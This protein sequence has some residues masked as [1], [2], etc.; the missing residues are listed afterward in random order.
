[1]FVFSAFAPTLILCML[2]VS[3]TLAE[4]ERG[5]IPGLVQTKYKTLETTSSVGDHDRE[6][7]SSEHTR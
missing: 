3:R 6:A 1:M 7:P 2:R 4:R 5:L